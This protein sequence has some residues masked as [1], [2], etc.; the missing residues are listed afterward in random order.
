MGES[1]TDSQS[2]N[3]ETFSTPYLSYGE[4]DIEKVELHIFGDIWLFRES[5]GKFHLPWSQISIIGE[6][7]NLEILKLLLRA[8]GRE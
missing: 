6:L 5:E 7:P 1:L 4:D 8:F 3:L 2:D